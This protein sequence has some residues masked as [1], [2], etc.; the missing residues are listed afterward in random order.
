MWNTLLLTKDALRSLPVVKKV[1]LE[2]IVQ[3]RI[4]EE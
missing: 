1:R 2:F 3:K 4:C